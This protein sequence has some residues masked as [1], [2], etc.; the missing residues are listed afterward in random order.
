MDVIDRLELFSSIVKQQGI[1]IRYEDLG[2]AA[3]GVC[4]CNQSMILFIDSALSSRDQLEILEE[5]VEYLTETGAKNRR[6]ETR[7]AG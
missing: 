1:Q 3:S 6:T 5:V 2:G 7:K 4:E